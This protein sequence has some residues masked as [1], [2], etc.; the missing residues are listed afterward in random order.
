MMWFLSKPFNKII[1]CGSVSKIAFVLDAV[2]TAGGKRTAFSWGESLLVCVSYCASL[3]QITKD[4]IM[5]AHC[6]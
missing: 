2:S 4:G 1:H 3:V 6:I 5:I